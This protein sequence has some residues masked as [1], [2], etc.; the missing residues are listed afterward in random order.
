MGLPDRRQHGAGA[1]L[2]AQHL[3]GHLRFA[4]QIGKQPVKSPRQVIFVVQPIEK[5]HEFV[6]A[7]A[8]HLGSVASEKRQP[9]GDSTNQAITDGM[10]ERVV[11]A[12]EVIQVKDRQAAESAT[13]R[14]TP[15][16]P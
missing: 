14:R 11:D 13:D 15:S 2:D 4:E 12:L 5:N 3:A 16:T 1:H 7:K 6:A 9:F 8:A 10:S